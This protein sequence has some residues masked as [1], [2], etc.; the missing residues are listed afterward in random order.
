MDMSRVYVG[1]VDVDVCFT[2]YV[3]N[4]LHLLLRWIGVIKS[5]VRYTVVC[6]CHAK[7]EANGFRV[8]QMKI[9][10]RFYKIIVINKC[11][12]KVEGTNIP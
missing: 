12:R 5:H 9:S 3:P 11:L 8:T 6:F 4:I 7:V 2:E 1:D 10:I